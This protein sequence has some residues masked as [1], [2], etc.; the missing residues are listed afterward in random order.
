[1]VHMSHMPLKRPGTEFL[2]E[3]LDREV[4][5]YDQVLHQAHSLTAAAAL[6]WDLCDGG[7]MDRARAAL[8][9]ADHTE[10]LEVVLEQL[11]ASKLVAA[12]VARRGSVNHS[13]RRMLSKTAVAAGIIIAS[14]VVYSIIAPSVAQAVSGPCGT[15]GKQCCT[16]GN[17]CTQGACVGNICN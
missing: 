17:P 13:R 8:A 10:S 4:L 3:K 15:I 12:P 14:P 6:V 2:V 5:V 9:N 7:T 1:M 11:V 16:T